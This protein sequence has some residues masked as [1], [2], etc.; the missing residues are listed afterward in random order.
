MFLLSGFAACAQ[1]EG[2]PGREYT[3]NYRPVEAAT[4]YELLLSQD[5]DTRKIRVPLIF[6][7]NYELIR[8]RAVCTVI[9]TEGINNSDIEITVDDI[10]SFTSD[11]QDKYL[12]ADIDLRIRLKT[13]GS[14]E[15]KRIDKINFKFNGKDI[16]CAV[17][18][19]IKDRTGFG[20]Y[21][22]LNKL[23]MPHENI[24]TL[25]VFGDSSIERIGA[26]CNAA[27]TINRVTYPNG[28]SINDFHFVGYNNGT[29]QPLPVNGNLD[30][31]Q[32]FV[33]SDIFT[34]YWNNGFNGQS[35]YFGKEVIVY[36]TVDETGIEYID[37][38]FK[39]VCYPKNLANLVV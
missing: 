23:W 29:E 15:D 16:A 12:I 20:T 30:I 38:F 39:A 9:G 14:F 4:D 8:E 26:Q 18:I 17:N 37:T 27:V 5:V 35:V 34:A 3:F 21:R 7:F 10:I 25:T 19:R 2:N 28:L 6:D 24:G 13:I 31:G 36:Y 11:E 32:S 1:Q 33:R 22:N